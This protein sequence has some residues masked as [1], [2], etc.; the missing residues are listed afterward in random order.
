VQ[1]EIKTNRASHHVTH[2]YKLFEDKLPSIE[3]AL[4]IELFVLESPKVEDHF[5]LQEKLWEQSGGIRR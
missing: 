1:I 4:G 2:L 3:P 5:S